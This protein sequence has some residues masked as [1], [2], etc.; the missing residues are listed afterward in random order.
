MLD[1]PVAGELQASTRRSSVL[2]VMAANKEVFREGS[3]SSLFK[4][5]I[6]FIMHVTESHS[7]LPPNN[8][9]TICIIDNVLTKQC[10]SNWKKKTSQ[11]CWQR[12]MDR[13]T[14]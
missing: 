10:C 7:N 4:G 9:C 12:K 13:T 3:T 11:N 2:G 6:Q 1:R 8:V 14:S 5:H